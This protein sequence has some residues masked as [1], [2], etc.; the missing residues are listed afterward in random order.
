MKCSLSVIVFI[1]WNML[2]GKIEI[3]IQGLTLKAQEEYTSY[4]K[5]VCCCLAVTYCCP[6]MQNCCLALPFVAL[7]SYSVIALQCSI[8]AVFLPSCIVGLQYCCL[9]V[10]LPT[11]CHS[12]LPPFWLHWLCINPPPFPQHLAF[13]SLSSYMSEIGYPS[14]ISTKLST[15]PHHH[16]PY[17]KLI[18]PHMKISYFGSWRAMLKVI[19]VDGVYKQL[20]LH[21][22][23]DVYNAPSII[24]IVLDDMRAVHCESLMISNG[25]WLAFAMMTMI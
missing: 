2:L 8:I 23:G 18:S 12:L 14:A 22:P 1:E 10:S 6:V 20:K 13:S 9:A 3:K 25:K 11:P 21:Q 4:I 24:F 7:Q 15:L 17:C 19:L 5:A 16:H